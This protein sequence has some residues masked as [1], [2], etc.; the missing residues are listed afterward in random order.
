MLSLDN[1]NEGRSTY[2]QISTK[3]LRFELD[4]DGGNA[5]FIQDGQDAGAVRGS[6]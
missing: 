6:V 5:G 2:M 4:A 3:F 1:I